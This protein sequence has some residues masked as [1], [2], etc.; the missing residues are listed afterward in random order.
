MWVGQQSLVLFSSFH[1][2]NVHA[3]Q[4]YNLSTTVHFFHLQRNIGL[5]SLVHP[6]ANIFTKFVLGWELVTNGYIF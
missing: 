3:A 6:V 1:R 5:D 4:D 2:Y